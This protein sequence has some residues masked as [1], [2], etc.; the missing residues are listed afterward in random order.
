MT[1]TAKLQTRAPSSALK[2]ML[3]TA[4]IFDEL[5]KVKINQVLYM[6]FLGY[7]IPK[8]EKPLADLS[9][10]YSYEQYLK[11][12]E[13]FLDYTDEWELREELSQSY[14]HKARKLSTS[15]FYLG[16][17][18]SVQ[19]AITEAKS[20]DV[21]SLILI[22]SGPVI[23]GREIRDTIELAKKD[24]EVKMFEE[25]RFY[26]TA[27]EHFLNPAMIRLTDEQKR[28]LLIELDADVTNLPKILT[29]DPNVVY[30][31]WSVGDVILV[32]R[33]DPSTGGPEFQLNYRVVSYPPTVQN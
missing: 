4:F 6:K 20:Q 28:I 12:R 25:R 16:P 21:K 19:E 15:V 2:L 1:S 32:G 23:G 9:I 10:D 7:E 29:T 18:Y 27:I 11:V 30:N 17:G 14:K 24:I 3:G 8:H 31:Q 33:Y 13:S 5:I 26:T 22:L